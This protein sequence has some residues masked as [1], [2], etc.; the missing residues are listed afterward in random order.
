MVSKIAQCRLK[1]TLLHHTV[2]N[3]W[4]IYTDQFENEMSSEYTSNVTCGAAIRGL[5]R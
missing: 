4:V 5:V 1:D 2:F 3:Y